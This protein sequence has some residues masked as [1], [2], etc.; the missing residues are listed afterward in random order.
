MRNILFIIAVAKILVDYTAKRQTEECI[1]K[2]K[3]AI[4]G[5]NWVRKGCQDKIRH[6]RWVR[7]RKLFGVGQGLLYTSNSAVDRWNQDASEDIDTSEEQDCVELSA[8][9]L[10]LGLESVF[11]NIS[12]LNVEESTPDYKCIPVESENGMKV[13]MILWLADCRWICVKTLRKYGLNKNLSSV[14]K[15]VGHL[16]K[17]VFLQKEQSTSQIFS[18]KHNLESQFVH[19]IKLLKHIIA[20]LYSLKQVVYFHFATSYCV[21]FLV[22]IHKWFKRRWLNQFSFTF[23]L[24]CSYNFKWTPGS[25]KVINK[26]T[27]MVSIKLPKVV[28]EL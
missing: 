22:F 1:L 24:Y 11:Q 2:L 21:T 3:N 7:S 17:N 19:L 10:W 15:D 28:E 27:N 5:L 12:L 8:L 26:E 18:F 20:R 9:I 23:V 6:R 14:A 16:R 4:L 13:T 25:S